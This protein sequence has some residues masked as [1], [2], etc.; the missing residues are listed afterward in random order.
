MIPLLVLCFCT[1]RHFEGDM[2]MRSQRRRG[3]DCGSQEAIDFYRRRDWLQLGILTDREIGGNSFFSHLLPSMLVRLMS[4]GYSIQQS[5]DWSF[6]PARCNA[7]IV[8]IVYG[9]FSDG[10]FCAAA[11]QKGLFGSF[12][13]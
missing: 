8:M 10:Q 4:F 9:A 6:S 11:V 5:P 2:T 7:C 1:L 13:P 3:L 12:R